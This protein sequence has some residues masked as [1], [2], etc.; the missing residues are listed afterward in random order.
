MKIGL[1]LTLVGLAISFTMPTF[2]Q[3][4]DTVDPQLRQQIDALHQKEGDA[5][6]NGDAAALAA[7]YTEDAVLVT[8]HGPISGREAIEKHFADLFQ[9]VQ[10]STHLAKC[11]QYSPRVIGTAGNEIWVT[12]DWSCTIKGQNF[13]PVDLKGYWGTVDVREGDDWKIQMDTWNLTSAPAAKP[14]PMASP[15]NQ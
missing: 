6:N 3:Q 11:D 5:F 9:K 15:S 4:K 8:D 14:S 2:A 10:F 1:I 13:G 7:L 12:G